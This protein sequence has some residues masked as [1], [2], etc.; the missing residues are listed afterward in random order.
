MT[1]E[2]PEV[3]G[4]KAVW[5]PG[6]EKTVCGHRSSCASTTSAAPCVG[7]RESGPEPWPSALYQAR[8]LVM[9]RAG[10]FLTE[11]VLAYPCVLALDSA[12]REGRDHASCGVGSLSPDWPLSELAST[13]NPGALRVALSLMLLGKAALPLFPPPHWQIDASTVS[14]VSSP[15]V[16]H[17]GSSNGICMFLSSLTTIPSLFDRG[18]RGRVSTI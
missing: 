15:F 3:L 12:L 4:R 5:G 6:T 2:C 8:V 7:S 17:C 16:S 10:S 11:K 1:G 9:P 13:V 18:P 14:T